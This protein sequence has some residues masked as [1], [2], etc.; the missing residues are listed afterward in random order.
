MIARFTYCFLLSLGSLFGQ[1]YIAGQSY[2]DTTGYVEY[3][4]GTMPIIISAPHGGYLEP[5]HI[6]DR[7]CT[8]CVYVRDGFTQ[9]L[10]REVRDA[11]VDGYGCAPHVIINLLHRKKFDANR[12]IVEAA[13]GNPTVEASWYAYHQFIDT[14]KSLI[15]QNHNR[16]IF[17]DFHGHG[18]SIQRLEIGYTLSKAELQLAD[19]VLDTQ[20]L[21]LESSIR[22]LADSNQNSYS[23]SELIRGPDSFGSL[24]HNQG[25][26]VVPSSSIPFPLNSEPY[27]TGGYNTR[28]HGSRFSGVFDGI[29]I[30]CNQSIRFDEV[31]RADFVPNLTKGI[32]EHYITH[33]DSVLDLNPCGITALVESQ[34][35][36]YSVEVFPNPFAN[37][38]VL[39]GLDNDAQ[40]FLY[41]LNGKKYSY[42]ISKDEK[43][44]LEGI[45]SGPYLAIIS[46]DG[47]KIFSRILIKRP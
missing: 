47:V 6:P 43:V 40:L 34:Y 41:D 38:I 27:F 31:A 11:F 32:F 35:Q 44:L 24:L 39:D 1:G 13:N 46:R 20:T 42:Q 2:L 29:Q 45:P 19:S 26:P 5:A 16:G 7:N 14:A 18:H 12:D 28:R 10:A 23:H 9:E 15:L 37:E 33:Y 30:E 22:S 17:Y 21:I 8:G 36:D 25:Y 4:P 3:L